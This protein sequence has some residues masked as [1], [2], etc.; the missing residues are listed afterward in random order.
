MSRN[1]RDTVKTYILTCVSRRCETEN[2]FDV[3][4]PSASSSRDQSPVIMEAHA[5]AAVCRI[6]PLSLII[7]VNTSWRIIPF[8]QYHQTC[9][10]ERSRVCCHL[11]DWTNVNSNQ[12]PLEKKMKQLKTFH[13]D[14]MLT[15]TVTQVDFNSDTVTHVDFNSDTV[16]QV[17]FNSDTV[18]QRLKYLF[19]HFTQWFQQRLDFCKLLTGSPGNFLRATRMLAHFLPS[20]TA[21]S[22]P[23]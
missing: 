15:D 7:V 12:V 11:H 6:V 3:P 17:D 8:Y 4:H 20:S 18:T 2:R 13:V 9:K 22:D 10:E 5:A 19:S 16:T 21:F 14:G 23:R 1:G